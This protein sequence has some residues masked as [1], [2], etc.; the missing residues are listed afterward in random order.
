MFGQHV[1][2][3]DDVGGKIFE[4]TGGARRGIG[5]PPVDGRCQRSNDG[6]DHERV[7]AEQR[8]LSGAGSGVTSQCLFPS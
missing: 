4:R 5:G 3:G 2:E 7:E 8:R 6:G 1:G